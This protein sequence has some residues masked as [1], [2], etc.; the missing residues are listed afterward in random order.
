MNPAS[1]AAPVERALIF[2]WERVRRVPLVLPGFMVL[3]FL[4]HAGAF[5]LFRVVYPPQASLE[6]PH[7]TITLLDR[8]R[9][10]HQALLRWADAEDIAP[11]TA[12][13]GITDRLLEVPYRPSYATVRTAPL[14]LP[15]ETSRV[16]YPPARDPL[17]LIRSVEAKPAAP[18]T[19]PPSAPTLVSFSHE[20]AARMRGQPTLALEKR[21]TKELEPAE[22]LI[23]VTDRGELRFV[24]LQRSS[25]NEAM[26]A[27]ASERLSRLELTPS[28]API[29][30]GRAT[31]QWGAD[32]Y[33]NEPSDT[34]PPTPTPR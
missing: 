17:A 25:G 10:D 29:A 9:P 7:P 28:A 16:Q 26:D 27:E 8:S 32:A 4:G 19:L 14:T 21:S 22:F 24:V 5:F 23:G 6:M 3:V 11:A 30:W 1:A 18:V 34:K 13:T 15:P 2:A 12:Q 31:I 20:L 33:R